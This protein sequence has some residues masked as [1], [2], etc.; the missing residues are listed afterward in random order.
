M[1][2][3]QLAEGGLEV[4]GGPGERIRQRGERAGELSHRRGGRLHPVEEAGQEAH[5]LGQLGIA[6]GGGPGKP[7][8]GGRH[9]GDLA[10]PF[11]EDR[12]QAHALP[13][14]GRQ[15][16]GLRGED[17]EGVVAVPAEPPERGQRVLQVLRL[18]VR[19]QPEFLDHRSQLLSRL[20]RKGVEEVVELDRQLLGGGGEPPA[21]VDGSAGAVGELEVGLLD[22]GLGPQHDLGAFVEGHGVLP[23]LHLHVDGAGSAL[24]TPDLADRHPGHA[25]LGVVD[26]VLGVDQRGRHRVAAGDS[27]HRAPEVDPQHSEDDGHRHEEDAQGRRPGAAQEGGGKP[28]GFD[29]GD[30]GFGVSPERAVC[31]TRRDVIVSAPATTRPRRIGPLA[32][33]SWNTELPW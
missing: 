4:G 30:P 29:P 14:Q 18:A 26:E 8:G 24:E 23:Q 9:T 16:V 27:G 19:G 21:V 2:A 1:A 12:E 31:G 15:V 32:S 28:H 13:H 22:E 6:A 33:S 17:V 20:E 10:L 5:G 3:G 7:F 11:V 25:H